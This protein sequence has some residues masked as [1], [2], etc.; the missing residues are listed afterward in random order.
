MLVLGSKEGG[1]KNSGEGGFVT[2]DCVCC[3]QSVTGGRREQDLKARTLMR[4]RAVSHALRRW[5]MF[6]PM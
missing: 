4:N 3:R 6:S 5:R 1:V 2:G